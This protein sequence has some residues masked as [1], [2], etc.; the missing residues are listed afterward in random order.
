M[1]E[2]PGGWAQYDYQIGT[3]RAEVNGV[4]YGTYTNE[5]ATIEH[6]QILLAGFGVE[7]SAQ[8]VSDLIAQKPEA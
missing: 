1:I 2:I 6:L 8:D 7:L 4:I 5:I 3:Y